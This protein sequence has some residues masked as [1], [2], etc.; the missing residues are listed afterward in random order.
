MSEAAGFAKAKTWQLA[1]HAQ[2]AISNFKKRNIEAQYVPDGQQARDVIL[3]LIPKGASVG[4]GDSLTMSQLGVLDY[5]RT[6]AD[7]RIFDSFTP[8]LATGDQRIEVMR[9]AL[10]ADVFLTGANAITLD[11]KIV[12]TDAVGN[13]VA[14][15]AFG[16]KKVIVAAGVNKLVKD[17]EAAFRRIKDICT[18]INVRRHMTAYGTT[19]GPPCG[20]TG[21]CSECYSPNRFCR[22]TVIVEGES[23]R[24]HA[25]G[26]RSVTYQEPRIYVIIV[27]E[28]LGL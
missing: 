7:Y 8:E 13:R 21:F 5:L 25:L 19:K 4:W 22:Y 11:G 3:G 2:V 28:E 24:Q 17:V 16:P 6:A 15:L 9:K 1:E 14:A 10:L 18:P 12:N 27:G 26:P 20:I 23:R